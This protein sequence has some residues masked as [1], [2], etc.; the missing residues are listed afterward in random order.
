MKASQRRQ[1]TRDPMMV[2]YWDRVLNGPVVELVFPE[3]VHG[4]GL[5]LGDLVAQA[6]LP[7]VTQ[8]KTLRAKFE[9]LH[10]GTHPLR[11]ALDKLATLDTIRIIEE[12]LN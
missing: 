10:D 8:L 9:E 6:A 12:P 5:R 11:L 7:E 4:A 3:E 2:A 1:T